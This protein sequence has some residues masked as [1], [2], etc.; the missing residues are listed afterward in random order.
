[1]QNPLWGWGRRVGE[2]DA[3]PE[4]LCGVIPFCKCKQG[5][6]LQEPQTVHSLEICIH[7][8]TTYC[9][10]FNIVMQKEPCILVALQQHVS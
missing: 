2:I 4:N 6:S 8:S 10:R 5:R 9:E 7:I 1:M 3:N